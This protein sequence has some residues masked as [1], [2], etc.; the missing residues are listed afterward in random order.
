ML[1]PPVLAGH[2]PG[3]DSHLLTATTGD[4]PRVKE[5]GLEYQYWPNSWHFVAENIGRQ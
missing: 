2:K 5:E 3:V 1:K 4:T